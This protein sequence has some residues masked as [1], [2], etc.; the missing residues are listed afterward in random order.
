M[1]LLKELLSGITKNPNLAVVLGTLLLC[2]FSLYV[3]LEIVRILR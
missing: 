3:V 2:G 1:K